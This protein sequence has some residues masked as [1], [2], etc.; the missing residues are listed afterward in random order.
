MIGAYLDANATTPLAPGVLAA[1]LP[2]METLYLNASSAA[3]AAVFSS[4]DPVDNARTAL[5]RLLGSRDLAS[6]IL[7]TSGA[8]EANSWVAA[9]FARP[10]SHVVA[11]RIEH[12]SLRN[13][14]ESAER[15]GAEVS[16]VS[17]DRDGAI[18]AALFAD[19]LRPDTA[20][21]TVMLANNETGVLQ[22]I[23]DLARLT[24]ELSTA[25]F[26]TDAT[27]AVGRIPVDFEH[28]LA[29]VDLVSLSG[30]KLHGPKG[31][32]ALLARSDLS[33]PPLIHGQQERGRRGGTYN[34]P[35]A[36]GLGE[37]A[38]IARAEIEDAASRMRRQ[39]DDVET[40]VLAV[41]PGAWV[42]G[43]R[44]ERLP[45]T[46]SITIPGLDAD[47]LVDRLAAV[48]ICIA[49]GSAC[50][51]GATAPSDTLIAMG[52]SGADAAATIRI[53]L[54]AYTTEKELAFFAS[55][56]PSALADLGIGG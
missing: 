51:A 18:D 49:A 47:A 9:A 30:H 31:I 42:N 20:L 44:V 5:A 38:R 24:R 22:P 27:Q 23:R 29:E 2:Y 54:S 52:L 13:A 8:S 14:L 55:H 56:L 43:A 25:V 15:A 46:T 16:W 48:G 50:S 35:G 41:A 40:M 19:A 28:D 3:A 12:P 36:A 7:L 34:T 33:L 26:H 45:N 10:G 11:S 1:M 53:S 6:E 21:A 39:R 17:P 32:G 37:A 4:D